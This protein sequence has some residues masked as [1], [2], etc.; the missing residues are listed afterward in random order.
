[1]A[2]AT[3]AVAA[4]AAAAEEAEAAAKARAAAAAEA[5]EAMA[6]AA[7][8]EAAA[9]AALRARGRSSPGRRSRRRTQIHDEPEGAS[10]GHGTMGQAEFDSGPDR[11][12]S[13]LANG[14]GAPGGAGALGLPAVLLLLACAAVL[15]ALLR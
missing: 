11:R 2:S 12:P 10:P 5:A 6:E 8:A 15:V 1:M 3:A 7:E 4:A 9:E 13:Q 14:G